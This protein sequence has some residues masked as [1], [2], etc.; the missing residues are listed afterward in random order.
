MSYEQ[1]RTKVVEMVD[2]LYGGDGMAVLNLVL[3]YMTGNDWE[4]LYNRLECD[5]AFNSED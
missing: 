1:K 2:D 5:G 4:H 3:D